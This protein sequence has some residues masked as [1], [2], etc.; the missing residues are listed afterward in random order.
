MRKSLGT[1][2]R[3]I[4]SCSFLTVLPGPAWVLLN[5]TYKPL[6]PPLYTYLAR[7]ES[8]LTPSLYHMTLEGGCGESLER[9]VRLMSLPNCTRTSRSPTMRA[10]DTAMNNGVSSKFRSVFVC[11]RLLAVQRGEKWLVRGWVKFVPALA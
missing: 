10:F 2:L 9:Q 6:F 1:W 3:E 7:R 11:V 4:S 8:T 5:K